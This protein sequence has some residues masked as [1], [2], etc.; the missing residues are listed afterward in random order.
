MAWLYVL[1]VHFRLRLLTTPPKVLE[2]GESEYIQQF[3][4]AIEN[5]PQRI[6]ARVINAPTL[7]YHQSSRQPTAVRDFSLFLLAK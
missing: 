6:H 5:Q 2:Y 4:M 1:A 3:G 7:R